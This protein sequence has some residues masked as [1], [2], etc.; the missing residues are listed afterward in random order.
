MP[1]LVFDSKDSI[2][3]EL[4]ELAAEVDGKYVVNVVPAKKLEEFRNNNIGLAK[5]RDSLKEVFS[6]LSPVIGED[7]DK[8]I[9]DYHSLLELKKKAE[10]G[11]I[12]DNKEFE[13][14]LAARTTEMKGQYEG[15]VKALA[16]ERDKFKNENQ[17]LVASS[18][19]REL[20]ISLR[21]AA[22]DPSLGVS[23]S[24]YDDVI[25]R[26]LGV[27]RY[28][29]GKVIPFNGSEVVYGA[30][31]SSPMTPKEWIAKLHD[32]APHLFKNSTGGGAGSSGGSGG[33]GN[34]VLTPE[35]ISK[36]SPAEYRKMREEGKIR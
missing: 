36:L 17:E 27:F 3:E 1:E 5:E 15:Q 32:Q 7:P 22:I 24:A 29:D 2:H 21:D 34:G 19:R 23:P 26:G 31:G 10:A 9:T 6:K 20:E 35:M 8:F 4:R 18:Q 30:D 14:A 33:S 16:S 13:N 25:R 12:K 11:E 28:K